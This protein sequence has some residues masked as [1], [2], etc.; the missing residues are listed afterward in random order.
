MTRSKLTTISKW[1]PLGFRLACTSILQH[2][3][4]IHS[5]CATSGCLWLIYRMVQLITD[6]RNNSDVVL[7][8]GVV[9]NAA[10]LISIASAFPW[11]REAHHK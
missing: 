8:M 10:V 7:A 3:G 4:G 6:H 11:V 1:T 2:L 9:T 5:G